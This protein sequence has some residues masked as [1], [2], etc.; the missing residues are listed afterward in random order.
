MK[1]N[2]TSGLFSLLG[3]SLATS[4]FILTILAAHL[5][6]ELMAEL[7]KVSEELFRPDRLPVLNFSDFEEKSGIN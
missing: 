5:L 4:P 2:N 3:L 7:G 6:S 1:S